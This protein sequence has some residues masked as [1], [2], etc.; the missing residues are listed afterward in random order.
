MN[1]VMDNIKKV[2]VDWIDTLKLL[3]IFYIYLGHLGKDAGKL[4]P[5]V[6][7][8]HVPLFF[9]ISGL[10]FK[11]PENNSE[12]ARRIKI[13]FTRIIL[14][15]FVFS[16]IGLIVYSL[17]WDYSIERIYES[18]INVLLGI[19]NQVPLASLWF[20]PC[21]F[22]VIVYYCLA[23]LVTK[24]PSVIFAAS[25][26][27]YCTTP[28]WFNIIKVPVFNINFALNY[29][30]FFSLGVMLA[31]KIKYSI[32]NI[33]NEKG[34][35]YL[36]MVAALLISFAYF[37]YSYQF[38]AFSLIQDIKQ[39]QVKYFLIFAITCVM[40]IPSMAIAYWINLDPFKRMG[41]ST[42]AL[43]GTEQALKVCVLTFL[44][45]VGLKPEINDP[46]QAVLFTML[47]LTVSYFTVIKVY[48]SFS[49]KKL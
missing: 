29:L 12:V 16:I 15:Y 36:L 39:T 45:M 2:R 22:V 9:F 38:G 25:L 42:I 48:E 13:S 26:A 46:L 34:V 10:F 6:F 27:F 1:Q 5:F 7:S 28:Y 19:R 43:C 41:R 11:I 23:S 32:P 33:I 21:L 24:R 35:K 4:Y 40:F 20:L 30:A 8:F 18:S 14:P 44:A 47:C 49:S 37:A 31:N 3:G 17:R